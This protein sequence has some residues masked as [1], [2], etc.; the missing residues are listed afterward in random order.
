LRFESEDRH[1]GEG[2]DQQREKAGPADFLHRLDQDFLI[3]TL[4]SAVFP[5]IE[6]LVRVLDDHDGRVDH[7]TDGH[8]D[9]AEGHDVGVDPEDLHRDEGDDHRRWDRDDRN[10]RARDVPQENENDERDDDHLHKQLVLQRVDRGF[11]QLGAVIGLNDLHALW[12][13]WL[14][15]LE[16]LLDARDDLHGVLAMA[17]HHHAGGH[18]SVTVQL[19]DSAAQLRSELDGG[20]VPEPDRRSA[21]AGFDDDLLEIGS[22]LHIAMR[23][24][25]VL[26]AAP[27]D[28]PPSYFVIRFLHRFG[29]LHERD[30]V[31]GELV[32]ID[33]DLV[34]AHEAAHARYFGNAG[35]GLQFVADMPVLQRA[36]VCERPLPSR[37]H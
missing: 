33:G 29:E 12:Q 10:D 7:R 19:R 30:A 2:D 13:R 3:G 36:Q 15:F 9:A 14:D 31:G 16:A 11:D 5:S 20:D 18:F 21:R 8:G 22:R 26:G 35:N 27:L 4:T 17:H 32:R 6:L 23:A 1:E 28:E 37:I 25:H 24:D 34:L